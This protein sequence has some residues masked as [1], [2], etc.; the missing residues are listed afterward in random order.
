M[1]INKGISK[2]GGGGGGER[3]S[4]CAELVPE[5]RRERE[6]E[7]ERVCHG[8]QNRKSKRT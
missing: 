7:R 2:R 6:R 3:V 1:L 5:T 4:L 8:Y